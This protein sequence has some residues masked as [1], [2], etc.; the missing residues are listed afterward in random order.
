MKLRDFTI[1]QDSIQQKVAILGIKY[2]FTEEELKISFRKSAFE[3]HPDKGGTREKFMQIKDAFEFLKE[4]AVTKNQEVNGK[5]QRT[6][7]GDL[8]S[9]L[10]NGLGDL[11]NSKSCSNCHGNGYYSF[12]HREYKG[13]IECP[14][15]YGTGT[16]GR[17]SNRWW[18]GMAICPQ[19]GG[20]G[21]VSA[22]A[23]EITLYHTCINCKGTGR[24]EIYNP[25]LPKNRTTVKRKNE[26]NRKKQYCEKCGALLRNDKCWRCD[27]KIL[28]Y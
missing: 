24:V 13:G 2:P 5:I 11:I 14:L 22:Y 3:N 8:L 9:E 1:G 12:I 16:I 20:I 15:C 25:V 17:K 10:G 6:V 19:C 4:F 26:D 27:S 28:S 18:G 21:K 23:K 7:E